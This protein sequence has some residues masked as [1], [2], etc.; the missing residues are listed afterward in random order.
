[1]KRL[2]SIVVLLS[3][4]FMCIGDVFSASNAENNIFL[5]IILDSSP[6]T[7]KQWT[8]MK[9]LL[10][11]SVHN[12]RQGD[13]LE[14][15]L[16]R[17][18]NP[19]TKMSI[20][21]G[22]L[23]SFERDQ[24]IE[25]VSGMHKE[26]LFDADLGKA[27]KTAF[28]TLQENDS[29]YRCG[30][31]VLTDGSVSDGQAG[32][33]CKMNRVLRERGWPVCITCDGGEANRRLLAAGNRHEID[34]RF[35]DRPFL[36]Q[37]IS[38]VRSPGR[39][40]SASAED[41]PEP[42][43]TVTDKGGDIPTAADGSSVEPV[44]PGGNAGT[45]DT[46][47]ANEVSWERRSVAEDSKEQMLADQQ[48]DDK[49]TQISRQKPFPVL[50]LTAGGLL[51]AGLFAAAYL[52][53]KDRLSVA[54]SH[55]D[56]TTGDGPSQSV[57]SHIV[58]YIG[59]RRQDLGDAD[60]ALEIT[61][62]KGLGSTVYIENEG[63]SDTHVRIFRARKILKVQNL[64]AIPIV[65]NGAEL[66]PKAKTQLDLPADIELAPGVSVTLLTEP[67]EADTEDQ[68]DGEDKA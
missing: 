27:M 64:A 68:S 67:I 11:Q 41:K 31:M 33:V 47:D 7:E 49:T 25:I 16:A 2:I 24:I 40:S 60:A 15:L 39:S 29:R 48:P 58:A 14:I 12:L 28:A 43:R 18:G 63:V 57:P 8:I 32:Q 21:L 22:Q 3:T 45:R 20:V 55:G 59:D 5:S 9:A 1:M 13:K 42:K 34:L 44:T 51:A 10:L 4:A 30:L 35:I 38:S 62:G 6:N 53:R 50:A 36:S 52:V 61:L 46:S 54:K 37:W 26:F 19:S 66:R 65:I 23:D 56:L 17:P